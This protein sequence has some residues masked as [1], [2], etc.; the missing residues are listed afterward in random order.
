[1]SSRQVSKS[2]RQVDNDWWLAQVPEANPRWF[3]ALTRNRRGT[4]A[5]RRSGF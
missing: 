5:G 1:M 3:P 2:V 4:G